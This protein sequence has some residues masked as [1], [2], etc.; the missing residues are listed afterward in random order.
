MALLALAGCA[1]GVRPPTPR[2]ARLGTG[3]VSQL[4]PLQPDDP[5]PARGFLLPAP[6]FEV[7]GEEVRLQALLDGELGQDLGL[8]W[9]ARGGTLVADGSDDRARLRPTSPDWEVRVDLMRRGRELATAVAQAPLHPTVDLAAMLQARAEAVPLDAEACGDPRFPARVASGHVGCSGGEPILLDRFLPLD[10]DSD[11]PMP[12]LPQR[13]GQKEPTQV[14]PGDAA[15]EAGLLGWTGDALGTWRGPEGGTIAWLPQGALRGPPALGPERLAVLRSDRVE[16][17]MAGSNQRTLLPAQPLDAPG[18]AAVHSPWLAVLEGDPGRARLR[19]QDLDRNRQT[20]VGDPA[21]RSDLHVDSRWLTWREG[22]D[23]CWLDLERGELRRRTLGAVRGRPS[24]R[25]DD[26]LLVPVR[27]PGGVALDAL[28]L[29]TGQHG[30]LLAAAG[31]LRLRGAVAGAVTVA[32]GPFGGRAS[33]L[34]LTLPAAPEPTPAPHPSPP[35]A[36]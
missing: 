31:D 36:P 30:T 7:E 19:L 32:Q 20:W 29:P 14:R 17:S 13:P 18:A 15:V 1:D 5:R 25:L 10:A 22:D 33:L 6:L 2:A 27:A 26:L 28:H 3:S 34:A 4:P 8:R 35:A 12:G 21:D 16:V 23:V 11:V 24:E 9:T